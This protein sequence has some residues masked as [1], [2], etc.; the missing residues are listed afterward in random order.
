MSDEQFKKILHDIK[1]ENRHDHEILGRKD[2]YETR[3][4]EQ[5]V[6]LDEALANALREH[7]YMRQR[8][9]ELR[10]MVK[11]KEGANLDLHRMVREAAQR[12]MSLSSLAEKQRENYERQ[13]SDLRAKL[14]H[15][16]DENAGL[17]KEVM[18]LKAQINKR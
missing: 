6:E 12:E 5:L 1:E 18:T 8:L 2:Y 14:M 4:P 17:K 3:T 16:S 13:I 10:S 11:L 7:S 9:Q 15:Y